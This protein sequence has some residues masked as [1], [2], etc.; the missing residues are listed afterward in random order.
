MKV[1]QKCGIVY[2]DDQNKCFLCG[3]LAGTP[4]KPSAKALGQSEKAI[5]DPKK[6]ENN[7]GTNKFLSLA[8]YALLFVFVQIVSGALQLGTGGWIVCMVI[9]AFLAAALTKGKSNDDFFLRGIKNVVALIG[10]M[11]L[12]SACIIIALLVVCSALYTTGMHR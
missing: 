6:N 7:E 9:I 5:N 10:G 4:P 3:A 11:I 2:G 8:Q 12:V 1:C